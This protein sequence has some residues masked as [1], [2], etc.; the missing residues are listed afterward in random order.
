MKTP[1]IELLSLFF[2]FLLIAI[3]LAV[4]VRLKLGIVK[5]MLIAVVRMGIQLTLVGFFLQYL[6]DWDNVFLTVGWLLMMIG[7]AAYTVT[8]DTSLRVRAFLLPVSASLGTATL[9]MLF[10]FN[11]AII[12]TADL[13]E[14]RYAIAIGGMLL[15]NSLRGGIIGIRNFYEVVRREHNCYS[16]HLALGATRIEACRPYLKNALRTALLPAIA[17]MSTMGLVFLPGMMTGQILG[18]TQPMLAIKYQIAIMLA[19]FS[20]TT[21]GVG[22]SILGTMHKAFDDF[23]MLHPE[24]VGGKSGGHGG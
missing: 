8:R 12:D 24:L 5:R 9:F 14:A 22:L 18:G 19:I 11:L 10:Y 6:F 3:P 16:Y 2:C 17:T 4:S 20:C 15:G 1:N 23:G 13:L 7:M 21:I